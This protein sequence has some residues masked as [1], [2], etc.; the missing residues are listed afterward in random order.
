[1]ATVFHFGD[2]NSPINDQFVYLD[3]S[4]AYEII[5][6]SEYPARQNECIQFTKAVVSRGGLLVLSTK[7]REELRLMI[8][9]K[10]FEPNRK[11]RK[12][13]IAQSPTL[14]I[15][16]AARVQ[17]AE[18]VFSDSGKGYAYIEDLGHEPCGNELLRLTDHAMVSYNIE[19]GDAAH[20][21]IARNCGLWDQGSSVHVATL[22]ADW[23]RISDPLL[24]LHVD[25]NTYNQHIA[26]T[27]AATNQ[28][29]TAIACLGTANPQKT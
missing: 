10:E 13:R 15:G 21:V 11:K 9:A 29:P 6:K 8:P 19:Y 18:T 23:L 3:T 1:M 7:T 14:I 20:Y 16:A 25:T 4:F 17:A 12:A 27:P 24:V 2:L 22:D 5:G 26:T 28:L